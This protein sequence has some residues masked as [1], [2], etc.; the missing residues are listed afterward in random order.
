MKTPTLKKTLA[1]LLMT[2]AF[3]SAQAQGTLQFS[4]LLDGLHQVPPNNSDGLGRAYITLAD[5]AFGITLDITPPLTSLGF[6]PTGAF[7]HGP[8]G[9]GATGPVIFNLGAYTERPPFISEYPEA[10]DPG[11]YEYAFSYASLTTAQISDLMA[12]LWYVNVTS[13]AFPDGEIRGQIQPVPE[14]S[15]LALLGLGAL[16]LPLLLRRSSR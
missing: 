3:C 4:L 5:N 10:T 2:T 8:A 16:I 9:L 15:T 14:P 1:L 11:G 12:G 13:S 6:L 7:V